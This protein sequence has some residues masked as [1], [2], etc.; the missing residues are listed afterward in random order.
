[1]RN[2]IGFF[3]PGIASGLFSSAGSY[4]ILYSDS[5]APRPQRRKEKHI[6]I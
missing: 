4:V 6:Y 5:Y 1:M 3:L 2:F